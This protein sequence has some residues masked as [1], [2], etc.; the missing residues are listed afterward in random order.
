MAA[1]LNNDG[2]NAGTGYITEAKAVAARYG[3]VDGSNNTTV[4]VA[5]Q[6]VAS[7]PRCAGSNATECYIVT[8]SHTMPLFLA[9]LVGYRG[10]VALGGGRGQ[11]VQAGAIAQGEQQQFCMLTLQTSGTGITIH[12]GPMENFTGCTLVSDSNATCTGNPRNPPTVGD[13]RGTDNGCG[14]EQ[15]SGTP[16]VTDPYAY[17]AASIPTNTCGSYHLEGD[18]L[19]VKWS[20][21]VTVPSTPICGDVQLTGNTTITNAGNSVLVIENGKLDYGGFTLAAASGL[22][23]IFS[24]TAGNYQHTLTGTGTLNFNA[25]DSGT[26]SGIAIYQDPSLTKNV[27]IASSGNNPTWDIT[28]LVYLPAADVDFKGAVNKSSNGQSC[29]IMV[30]NS[31]IVDGTGWSL[32]SGGCAQAGVHD[33]T[34]GSAILVQ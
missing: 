33:D 25:P 8:I 23:I 3:F 27:G 10:N 24:G 21:N 7:V 13:A 12:G 34:I 5:Y 6:H 28:G 29:F 9:E 18:P 30:A 14:I 15:N 17:L 26:W 19:V 2:A 31:V 16:L 22:T 4:S 32:T 20:N 11:T 1:A